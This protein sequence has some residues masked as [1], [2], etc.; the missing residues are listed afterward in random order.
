[1]VGGTF[2]A[3]QFYADIDG[4]PDDP[5]VQLAF[6]ELSFF[7]DMVHVLGTYPA[8]GTRPA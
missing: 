8:S 1:M 2:T 4:H 5:A 3:T 7:T 6:E